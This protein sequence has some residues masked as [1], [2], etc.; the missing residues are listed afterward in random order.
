[1]NQLIGLNR[2][3][4]SKAGLRGQKFFTSGPTATELGTVRTFIT[5]D[6]NQ[7]AVVDELDII[8]VGSSTNPD[9]HVVLTV[10]I[11]GQ[12]MRFALRSLAARNRTERYR[13]RPK[14]TMVVPP[15]ASMTL[16]SDTGIYASSA[17]LKYRLM[18]TTEA[19]EAGY[20]PSTFWCGSTGAIA[21]AG[22]PQTLTGLAAADVTAN[23][24]LEI[25]GIAITGSMPTATSAANLEILLEFTDEAGSNLKVIKGLYASA[26]PE[27]TRPTLINNCVIRGPMGYGLRVTAGEAGSGSQITVW[28]KYGT[29]PYSPP[30]AGK[31]PETFPGNGV[32]PGAADAFNAGKYFW[33]YSE[34]TASAVYEFFPATTCLTTKLSYA[35]DGYALAGSAAGTQGAILTIGRVAPSTQSFSTTV[36][37]P[38]GGAGE[39]SSTVHVDDD[40][41]MRMELPDRV[42]FAVA[43]VSGTISKASMLAWG[44][45]GGDHYPN[46]LS[47]SHVARMFGGGT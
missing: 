2:S 28:G 25:N 19:I 31:A 15:S 12:S 1:M 43:N 6:A 29:A 35:I 17:I 18:S 20:Y 7:V 22:T 11:A 26:D 23:R 47:T 13:L 9:A 40:A 37:T 33:V 42:G 16:L 27:V 44:R 34:A 41:N 24:Y 38:L 36:V 30:T 4:F 5:T 21:L 14:G 10:T 46:T 8:M 39:G 3:K 45:V 32:I